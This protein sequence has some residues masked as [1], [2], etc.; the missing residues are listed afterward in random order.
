MIRDIPKSALI[1]G[2]MGL[3]PFIGGAIVAMGWLTADMGD[4]SAGGYPLVVPTDGALVLVR[5]GTIIL[6]FMSGVLW[7]FATRAGE[8]RAAICYALSVV[9]ALWVFFQVTGGPITMGMNLMFGF[10]GLLALDWMFWRWEL[11]PRWWMA[12]RV[13]L[14]GVVLICLLPLVV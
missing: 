9:P 8:G 10:A 3:L 14:T 7:G 11:A 6:C 4:P 12:L 5:Y 13:P 2:A 1:L